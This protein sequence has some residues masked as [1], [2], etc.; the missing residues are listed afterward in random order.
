MKIL[1]EYASVLFFIKCEYSPMSF[2]IYSIDYY[3]DSCQ[4]VISNSIMSSTFISW[5]LLYYK[6]GLS[7]LLHWFNW[8]IYCRQYGFM[9]SNF[10]QWSDSI[11]FALCCDA[12]IT[13]QAESSWLRAPFRHVP[14]ILRWLSHFRNKLFQAHLCF[15]APSLEYLQGASIPFHGERRLETE[16]RPLGI[17]LLPWHP[18]SPRLDL[19]RLW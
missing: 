6:E 19:S 8:I 1:W 16:I 4:M 11:T 12:P 18:L 7:P 14:I 2:N 15:P 17:S 10:S 3:C 9:D 5:S 13:W